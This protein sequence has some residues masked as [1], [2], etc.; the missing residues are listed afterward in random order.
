MGIVGTHGSIVKRGRGRDLLALHVEGLRRP[1]RSDPPGISRKTWMP[2]VDL[3]RVYLVPF[4]GFGGV[5]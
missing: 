4:D 1:D 5:P 2:R 3:A